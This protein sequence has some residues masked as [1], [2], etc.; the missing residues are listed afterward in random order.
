[1]RSHRNAEC[2]TCHVSVFTSGQMDSRWEVLNGNWLPPVT[3]IALPGVASDIWSIDSNAKIIRSGVRDCELTG[4]NSS[5]S[6]FPIFVYN[7]Y[8]HYFDVMGNDYKYILFDKS[9]YYNFN[10]HIDYYFFKDISITTFSNIS[11]T[12][13]AVTANVLVKDKDDTT[14]LDVIRLHN[15]DES[16]ISIGN[17]SIADFYHTFG[18]GASVCHYASGIFSFSAKVNNFRGHATKFS[19]NTNYN[20]CDEVGYGY[21]TGNIVDS[22]LYI[23]S[24]SASRTNTCC[25]ECSEVTLS[26]CS[27]LYPKSMLVTLGSQQVL[28]SPNGPCSGVCTVQSGSFNCKPNM[29]AVTSFGGGLENQG[30]T[31]LYV[32]EDIVINVAI[33]SGLLFVS[34]GQSLNCEGFIQ[35]GLPSFFGDNLT[36][37]GATLLYSEYSSFEHIQRCDFVNKEVGLTLLGNCPVSGTC[38]V[39]AIF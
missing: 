8:K 31:Y 10:S 28:S 25:G 12:G 35:N 24:S 33:N 19:T 39:T 26:G 15:T 23:R 27:G 36:F 17:G 30:H 9:N 20:N 38:H 37:P 1:M 5:P 2:C 7:Q 3:G 32:A 29:K 11:G 21:G 22:G 4:A 34:T 16:S 13:T 18:M 14:L 6:G